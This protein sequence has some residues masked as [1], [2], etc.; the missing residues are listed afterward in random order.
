[1]AVVDIEGSVDVSECL[2]KKKR[3]RAWKAERDLGLSRTHALSPGPASSAF[4]TIGKLLSLHGFFGTV[5]GKSQVSH[6]QQKLDIGESSSDDVTELQSMDGTVVASIITK[7][8]RAMI[9]LR[10]AHRLA[11]PGTAG[12]QY[13]DLWIYEEGTSR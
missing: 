9:L 13:L 2:E 1:M 6:W 11:R 7:S 8:A 5:G 10:Q 4:R 3:V 12:S